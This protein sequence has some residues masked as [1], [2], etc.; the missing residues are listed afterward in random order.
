M[1]ILINQLLQA[2]VN[3]ATA[4]AR[5]L[6]ILNRLD[7]L[8]RST[9]LGR[10]TERSLWYLWEKK[11]WIIIGAAAGSV[12]VFFLGP[13]SI[14]VVV[15]GAVVGGVVGLAKGAAMDPPHECQD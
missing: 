8:C 15:A 6:E 14:P 3:S 1:T 5:V 4:S 2:L 9:G 13:P 7:Q 10:I 12:A 11:R